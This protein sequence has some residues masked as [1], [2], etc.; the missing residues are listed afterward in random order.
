MCQKLNTKQK[1]YKKWYIIGTH[2]I[3]NHLQQGLICFSFCEPAQRRR[4]RDYWNDKGITKMNFFFLIHSLFLA[5]IC[6]DL[7]VFDRFENLQMS[8][9]N[10]EQIMNQQLEK[11]IRVMPINKLNFTC[12]TFGT[13]RIV[14]TLTSNINKLLKS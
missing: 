3:G 9:A 11:K 5:V 13:M 14:F 7:V 12:T 6:C 2:L 10:T 8:K 4:S 1:R